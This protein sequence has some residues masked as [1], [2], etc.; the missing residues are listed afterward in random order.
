M[1][2]EILEFVFYLFIFAGAVVAFMDRSKISKLIDNNAKLDKIINFQAAQ[3]EKLKRR[4][5]EL[6]LGEQPASK[7]EL[8]NKLKTQIIQPDSASTAAENLEPESPDR[9]VA[10][11]AKEYAAISDI[12]IANEPSVEKIN[13]WINKPVTDAPN[14]TDTVESPSFNLDTLLKGNALLWLGAIVLG[15]GGI[16]L[17]KY[18]IDAGLLPPIVRVIAGAIFGIGLVVGAEYLN[19]N[20]ERF[21]INSPTI[22]AALASGGIIN[23]FAI[24]LISFDFYHFISANVAFV[25]LAIITLAST[26]LA[27]RFGAI[28][29][30]IGIVGAYVVPVLVSTG[31]NNIFALLLYVAFVSLSAVWVA[32]EVKQKWLWWQSFIGHTF[33]FITAITMS[34][35]ADFAVLISFTVFTIYLYVLTGVIGWKL[36][37]VTSEPFSLKQL[38]MP[39][40]EQLGVL[41]PLL[42]A[43]AALALLSYES[44]IWWANIIVTTVLFAAATR[45]SALDSWPFLALAFGLSTY[46]L[47]PNPIS[48]DDNFFPFNGGYL[49]IQ[50]AALVGMLFSVY[51]I[52]RFP[53]RVS[54]LLLLVV[55]PLTLFGISY[56]LSTNEAAAYLYPV[57]ATELLLIGA[58]SSF[59]ATK[60]TLAEQKV[61]L[62]VLANT[63]LAL[64][65]TMLLNASAFTLVLAIQVAS[66]SYLSWKYKVKIPDWLFKAALIVVVSRLTFAPWL[67]EYKDE[68]IFS[69][70]WTLIVYPLILAIV[71][72]ASKYNPSKTLKLWF[73]GILLHITALL[74][75]TE[76]SYQLIGDYPNFLD[77]SFKEAI[78]LAFNWLAL[79]GVYLWRKQLSSSMAKIYHWAAMVL[80]VGTLFM[81]LDISLIS[82]PFFQSQ[83]TGDG[84]V[85]WLILMW[86]IPAL[87]LCAFIKFKLVSKEQYKAVLSFIG[88]LTFLFI[89]GEIRSVFNNGLL[90]WISPIQHAELY[91]YSV[92]W[93]LIATFTIFFAQH[94]FNQ[95]KDATQLRNA[96]F[97]CLAL[98]ILKVFIVD[99]SSLDGLYRAIS[100]IGL[101]LCLVGI[102][103]LFQKLQFNQDGALTEK[104]NS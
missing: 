50:I 59:Y 54:Y 28:L 33:W 46:L 27:L 14:K 68:L 24:T 12:Q 78:L 20:K 19:R 63:T 11:Q 93:L 25:L 82:N 70:H 15:L 6:N 89:N 69:V 67:A 21:N 51:M 87:I 45:H 95:S 104:T 62:L 90:L 30:A 58:A 77:L 85:N 74:I 35:G 60:V 75:T 1:E 96:G 7:E 44:H 16:F 71:W 88:I 18:S 4:L 64:C 47:L 100:F 61:T 94:S 9:Q 103:W 43:A 84:I 42:L 79:A 38:I 65:F 98:V 40:R 10:Y 76:T 23:C 83:A 102:G 99:M 5:Q 97:G 66:M 55:T 81:H 34:N 72:F 8:I 13:P 26:Y 31:S 52:K 37:G 80:I 39:R 49:F 56:I 22:S 17:A 91:T 36:Q 32:D 3:I 101:G 73:S 92:V 86:A 57:W 29:A 53:D 48:Y 41:V 2:E